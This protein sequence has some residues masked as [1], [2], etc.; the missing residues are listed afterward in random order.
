MAFFPLLPLEIKHVK[1]TSKRQKLVSEAVGL[2]MEIQWLYV[3]LTFHKA[4]RTTAHACA[5]QEKAIQ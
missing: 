4:G 5:M 3:T 2:S 1:K